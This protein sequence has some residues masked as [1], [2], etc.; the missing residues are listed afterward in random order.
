MVPNAKLAELGKYLLELT[1]GDN[2]VFDHNEAAEV[3]GC[4]GKELRYDPG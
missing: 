2:R 3:T 1:E 4:D